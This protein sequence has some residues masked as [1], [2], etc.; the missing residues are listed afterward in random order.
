MS[1][2]NVKRCASDSSQTLKILNY[3]YVIDIYKEYGDWYLIARGSTAQWVRKNTLEEVNTNVKPMKRGYRVSV[4]SAAVKNTPSDSGSTFKTLNYGYVLDIYGEFGDWYL[5]ARGSTQQWVKKSN[6]EE[7]TTNVSP[8]KRGYK[9]S[10][11]SAAVKNTP[12]DS[13]P[14]Y[15][16]LNYGYELDI[17]GEFGDWYLVARGDTQQWIKKNCVSPI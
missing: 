16:T 11:S 7:I 9:I 13:A 3:G 8:M 17:Y 4:S 6:L 15:K 12:S 2:V 5:V 1:S 10:V 14:T